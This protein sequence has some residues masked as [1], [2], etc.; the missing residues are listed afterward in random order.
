MI[1]TS[2]TASNGNYTITCDECGYSETDPTLP[3]LNRWFRQQ[4]RKNGC[5]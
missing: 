1:T 4:H 5:N 2:Y 3:W